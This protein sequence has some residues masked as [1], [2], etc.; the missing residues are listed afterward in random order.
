MTTAG[1]R[2]GA[3]ILPV[4]IGIDQ[5]APAAT[6]KRPPRALGLSQAIGDSVDRGGMVA[7]AAMAA[8]NFDVFSHGA[9]AL[10]AAAPRANAVGPAEDRGGGNWRRLGK[11]SAEIATSVVG[12]FAAGEFIDAPG[13][14]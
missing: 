9:W 5:A 14:G 1:A 7:Q 3:L 6:V 10:D 11:L 12:S 2:L 8:L 13:V 4:G